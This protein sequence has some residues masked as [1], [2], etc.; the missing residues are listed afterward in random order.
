MHSLG[1]SNSPRVT[2]RRTRRARRVSIRITDGLEVFVVAPPGVSLQY[3][4]T[5]LRQ[6]SAWVGRTL[7]RI[8]MARP[9][10]AHGTPLTVLGRNYVLDVG[11][12]GGGEP[13]VGLEGARITIRH[14]EETSETRRLLAA[15]MT[16][17]ARHA[18]P[19]IVQSVA[20]ELGFSFGRVQIR[21]QRTRWGS[22]SRKGTLT[23]NWRLVLLPVTVM[24]YLIIHE[25][26]HLRQMNHSDAF[27]RE[28]ERHD[29]DWRSSERWLRK[30]GRSV[31][32]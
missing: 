27:W 19:P 22:C 8:E 29:P 3:L 21:N 20:V 23:F 11:P 2:I 18:L 4:Q 6:K 16:E 25:L 9:V 7:A 10:L 12:A 26:C 1:K 28:V 17:F 13:G 30:H 31:A 14:D 15:W 32:W 5:F 24:R